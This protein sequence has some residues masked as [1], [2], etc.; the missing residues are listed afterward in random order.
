MKGGGWDWQECLSAA[1]R[2]NITTEQLDNMTP[3]EL[4]VYAQAYRQNAE[5]AQREKQQEL[6]LC[7]LLISRFVWSK[8]VPPFERVFGGDQHRDMSDEQMLLMAEALNQM[9]GGTDTRKE[10]DTWQS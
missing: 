8:K 10:A 1:A 9:F 5:Q 3:R 2:L 7:A 4:A 6:Y